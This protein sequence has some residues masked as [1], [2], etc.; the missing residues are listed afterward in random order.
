MPLMEMDLFYFAEAYEFPL[1]AMMYDL[2]CH[3]GSEDSSSPRC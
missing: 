3:A 2:T 1:L